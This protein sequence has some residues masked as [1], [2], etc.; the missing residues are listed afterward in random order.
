MKLLKWILHPVS[1]VLI[2]LALAI[3]INRA[4]L[5]AP[6]EEPV[7]T[8]SLEAPTP[9]AEAPQA[10]VEEEKVAAAQPPAITPPEQEPAA[11][12]EPTPPAAAVVEKGVTEEAVVAEVAVSEPAAPEE[13][14]VVVQESE[15][16]EEPKVAVV[17]EV[18]DVAVVT[19]PSSEE[20]PA[21]T[22]AEP[23]AEPPSQQ[24]MEA[25]KSEAAATLTPQEVQRR[26]FEARRAA[27]QGNF[28]EAEKNY[29]ELI[30]M[31]PHNFDLYGELGDLYLR[32]RA[33]DK[34][35]EAYSHAAMLL[36]QSGRK[37]MAWQVVNFIHRISPEKASELRDRLRE[38]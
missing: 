17:E 30:E 23:V 32:S 5:F 34:A 18:T 22:A 31:F 25:E 16:A 12:P 33:P 13:I 4:A 28:D 29:L 36:Y 8:A 10:T 20:Q 24:M 26:L 3:Y 2:V 9:Q 15:V 19:E 6:D 27:W 1:I 37:G 38:R 35:I 11:A 14:A 21:T 7:K